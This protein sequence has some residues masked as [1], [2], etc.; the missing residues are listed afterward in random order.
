[1]PVL[2]K[3][4]NMSIAISANMRNSLNALQTITSQ[5]ATAQ[6]RLSTGLKVNS[7][8]DNPT[9]YF[10]AQGLNNRA[11]DLG[12]LLD[13]IGNSLKT[14]KAADEGIKSIT[15]LVQTAKGIAAAAK[16]ADAAGRTTLAAQYTEIMAQISTVAGDSSFNGVGVKVAV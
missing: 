1:M 5:S 16:Q 11:S 10:T 15:T 3:D 6:D 8:L 14:L 2:E 13:G 4:Y 9:S 12:T 7:A